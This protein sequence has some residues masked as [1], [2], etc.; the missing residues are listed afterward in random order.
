MNSTI[1][2][3]QNLTTSELKSDSTFEFGK[4][5][6]DNELFIYGEIIKANSEWA[7]TADSEINIS[8]FILKNY[9]AKFKAN[10]SKKLIKK[11]IK[12][13]TKDKRKNINYEFFIKRKEGKYFA[14]LF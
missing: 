3:S 5:I 14:Y 13:L 4:Y 8:S 7:I 9:K 10:S 6:V 2:S 11:V 1:C 12:N